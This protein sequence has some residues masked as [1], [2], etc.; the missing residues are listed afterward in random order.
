MRTHGLTHFQMVLAK[1]CYAFGI[2]ISGQAM[3]TSNFSLIA[4]KVLILQL[5]KGLGRFLLTGRSSPVMQEDIL[6]HFKWLDG[7]TYY[8]WNN[9]GHELHLRNS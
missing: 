1:S 3:R 7:A 9:F 5:S 8:S 6:H 4:P 2:K